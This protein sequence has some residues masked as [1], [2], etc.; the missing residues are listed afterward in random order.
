MITLI[1]MVDMSDGMGDKNGKLLF[2]I[3]RHN[4]RFKNET[5]GKKI[6]M[7][8]RTWDSL[9]KKLLRNRDKYVLTRNENFKANSVSVI[10]SIDEVLDLAN[11]SDVVVVGGGDIFNQMIPYADKLIITHVHEFNFGARVFFPEFSPR[12][13]KI[14]EKEKF[15]EA[16]NL[17]SFTFATY[18][19][20]TN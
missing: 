6:V 13:W 10:H 1:V 17:P 2:N 14:Q 18:D 8:R 19:K 4:A 11:D 12:D 16:D 3:P 15:E 5:K 9:P 7:G 20:K